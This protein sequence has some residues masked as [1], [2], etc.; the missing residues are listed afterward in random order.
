MPPF[1]VV[2]HLDVIDHVAARVLSNRSVSNGQ[3]M[4]WP[5]NS[6]QL[7]I[8]EFVRDENERFI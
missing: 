1:N 5:S 6:E 3:R 7:A 2:K 8:M 4:R